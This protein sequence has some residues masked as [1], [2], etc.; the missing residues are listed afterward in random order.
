[1]ISLSEPSHC[2][3]NNDDNGTTDGIQITICPRPPI[4]SIPHYGKAY[5]VAPCDGLA[6]P[7]IPV[8]QQSQYGRWDIPLQAKDTD[9][10]WLTVIPN[11]GPSPSSCV[12]RQLK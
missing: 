9:N 6:H 11:P 2:C 8:F 12:I 5:P 10:C 4:I 7:L 3:C 1:M